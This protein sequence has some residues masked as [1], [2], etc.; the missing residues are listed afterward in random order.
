[1]SFILNARANPPTSTHIHTHTHKHTCTHTHTRTHTQVTV[2]RREPPSTIQGPMSMSFTP[3]QI[4]HLH[5]PHKPVQIQV[6]PTYRQSPHIIELSLVLGVCTTIQGPTL[7][8][9]AIIREDSGDLHISIELSHNRA[10]TRVY[11]LLYRAL[12]LHLLHKPVQIQVI[13]ICQ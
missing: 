3:E 13:H 1:M 12:H 9:A 11:V 10:L 5:L 7:A 4:R 6:I 2:Q 8:F